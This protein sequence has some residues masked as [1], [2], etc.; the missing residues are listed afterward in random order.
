MYPAGTSDVDPLTPAG[1]R[2]G[3]LCAMPRVIDYPEVVQHMT[4]LGLACLYPNSGA[5]GFPADVATQSVGWIGPDDPSIRPAALPLIRRVGPPYVRALAALAGRAWREQLDGPVWVQPKAHWAYELMFGSASWMPHLLREAGLAEADID[6][7]RERHDGSAIEFDRAELHPFTRM[8]EGLLE[9]L[10]GSDFML[11]F[12]GRAVL[13]TVHHH[14]QLWWTS[15][16]EG[17]IAG[18]R[19]MAG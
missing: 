8:V 3:R 18:M 12:P 9:H 5:F 4:A 7:L 13:C 10:L 14:K 2:C 19:A 11:A 15:G 1:P 17:L 6:E 16:D